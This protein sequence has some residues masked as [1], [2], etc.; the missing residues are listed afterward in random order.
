MSI[1]DT[2]LDHSRAPGVD[3]DE[4]VEPAALVRH[5]IGENQR[6]VARP[7]RCCAARLPPARVRHAQAREAEAH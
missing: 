7:L 6:S 3:V 4:V 5:A 2:S 1:D